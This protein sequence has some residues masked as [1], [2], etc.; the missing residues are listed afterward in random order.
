MNNK[1][2]LNLKKYRIVASKQFIII[3]LFHENQIITFTIPFTKLTALFLKSLNRWGFYD[4]S[5][6]FEIHWWPNF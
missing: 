5:K 6:I 2:F 3:Y 4:N 1:E